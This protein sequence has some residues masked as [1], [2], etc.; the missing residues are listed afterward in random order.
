MIKDH[1][2]MERKPAAALHELFFPISSKGY[3]I[4]VEQW[5][6]QEI[7]QRVDLTTHRTTSERSYHGATFHSS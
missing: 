3:F 7:S 2:D 4:V 1:A 6:E 5:L